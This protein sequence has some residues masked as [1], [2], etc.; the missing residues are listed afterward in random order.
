MCVRCCLRDDE[1]NCRE[2]DETSQCD[3][4]TEECKAYDDSRCSLQFSEPEQAQFCEVPNPI[5]WPPS[6]DIPREQERAG[7]WQPNVVFF[8]TADDPN[9]EDALRERIIRDITVTGIDESEE[10]VI[11]WF[12][13]ERLK[14]DGL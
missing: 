3:Y 2:A 12:C 11:K 1:Q 7:R 10:I 6:V 13:H 9:V 8:T 14:F 4:G 5:V